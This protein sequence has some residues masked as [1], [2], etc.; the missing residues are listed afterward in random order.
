[1]HDVTFN[2]IKSKEKKERSN[3]DGRNF[4]YFLVFCFDASLRNSRC[5]V[6]SLAVII[7]KK[8]KILIAFGF[9]QR[10]LYAHVVF[11]MSSFMCATIWSGLAVLVLM[12]TQH[13][14]R[15]FALITA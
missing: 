12:T 11:N 1:M 6:Q 7:V 2:G 5:V 10:S 13:F 4:T 14:C 15:A 9:C 8:K 3:K